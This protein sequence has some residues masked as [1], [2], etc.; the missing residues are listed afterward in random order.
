[1]MERICEADANLL[2]GALNNLAV[3]KITMLIQHIKRLSST[4]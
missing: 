4:V 2:C 1:L 3:D